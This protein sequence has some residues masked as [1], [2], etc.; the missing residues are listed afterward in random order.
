VSTYKTSRILIFSFSIPSLEDL[1]P[2][3]LQEELD[4]RNLSNELSSPQNNGELLIDDEMESEKTAEQANNCEERK[5]TIVDNP[6][7]SPET[8]ESHEIELDDNLDTNHD[9]K[10]KK[11]NIQELNFE[12]NENPNLIE[13]TTNSDA[14]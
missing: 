12:S 13:E 8:A 6:D 11:E 1:D 3:P 2:V 9:Q 14:M 4:L 7:K 10:E 5:F